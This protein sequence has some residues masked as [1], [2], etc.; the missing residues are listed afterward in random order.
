M[1]AACITGSGHIIL[2][3]TS[4][5]IGEGW[6]L[7]N[8]VK[9]AMAALAGAPDVNAA[10]ACMDRVSAALLQAPQ[11]GA[12]LVRTLGST[13]EDDTPQNDLLQILSAA[14]DG[15]R[16]AQEKGQAHGGVLI[17]A[18]EAG[19]TQL[20]TDG[21]LTL[22][23]SLALSRAWVRAGLVPPAQLALSDRAMDSVASGRG[24]VDPGDI[25]GMIDDMFGDLIRQTEGDV[26]AL[27]EALTE[28]LPSL[29][30]EVRE[31]LITTALTRPGGMFGRLGRAFL[32]DPSPSTRLAA[33]QGLAARLA[34][35]RLEAEVAADLVSLRSWLPEDA[36][37]VGLDTLLRDAM[38]RGVS[39]GAVAQPWQVHKV[40]ATLPDGTGAQSIGVSL[41]RGSERALAMLLL[42]QDFGV[43]DAYM[44]PCTSASEQRKILTSI[45]AETSALPVP[46][47][48]LAQALELALADGLDHG[49]P[50]AAGL[51]AIADACGLTGLRPQGRITDELL[52]A[53]DPVGHLSALSPQAR[54]KLI[55][56]SE[57][58]P[59]DHPLTGSWF[60]DS[61]A[62][63]TVLDT[64]RA[65]RAMETALWNWLETRRT[66][67]ARIMA[68]SALLL[69]A[70]GHADA[71]GFATTARS[72]LDRRA[73]RKIPIM[74]E[75]H[76]QTISA[77]LHGD[78]TADDFDPDTD[79]L[80]PPPAPEKKGE[81]GKLLKGTSLSPTWI[82][83]Y[84]A[85]ICVAPSFIPPD[86]WLAPVLRAIMSALT[87][88]N[89]HRCI[90][91]LMQRYNATL[92]ALAD[93][94]GLER[95][96]RF[97]DTLGQRNWFEGFMAGKQSFKPS[98]PAKTLG[99][100][101]KALL[102]QIAS[103]ADDPT[104]GSSAIPALAAWLAG[105]FAA[106]QG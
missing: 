71:P 8:S 27:H 32:L 47:G 103:M 54:G 1:P 18:L 6:M 99:P 81:L 7:A 55:N 80:P 93:P 53:L 91:L 21:E 105:R 42:K 20:D 22:P 61:D 106:V 10:R 86:R 67:W 25:E 76:H 17:A 29:P 85:A 70:I 82:D 5:A 72:L 66:W 14:L 96:L 102:R 75:I 97:T 39:G 44:I 92:A 43:K 3:L 40:L 56:A 59:D 64:A 57:F 28:M 11:D 100:N 89:L 78:A 90:D 49:L 23:G 52:S 26:A 63:R 62:S 36:A 69:Q 30:A 98:W 58:W 51:I 87:E 33:V 2:A 45:E 65:P 104:S 68:R 13:A 84:L 79:N 37:R 48:Y 73:L 50:P 19:V 31:V 83:G 24:P 15:A 74:L 12:A 16:M 77:W 34:A 4:A 95:A 35:G 101:D 46:P 94:K 38:R 60:E 88:R 41:Q 9:T